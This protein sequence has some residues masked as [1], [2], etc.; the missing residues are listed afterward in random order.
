M[1]YVEKEVSGKPG[2]ELYM[3]QFFNATVWTR[4]KDRIVTIKVA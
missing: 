3:E 4:M 1:D 2:V